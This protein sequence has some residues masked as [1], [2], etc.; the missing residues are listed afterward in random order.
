MLKNEV[1]HIYKLF[2]QKYRGFRMWNFFANLGKKE[3]KK[4]IFMWRLY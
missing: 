4:L 1:N 3:E 2:R